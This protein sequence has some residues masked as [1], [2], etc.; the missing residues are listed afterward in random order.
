[1]DHDLSKRRQLSDSC[2]VPSGPVIGKVQQDGS[3]SLGFHGY[4][5]QGEDIAKNAKKRGLVLLFWGEKINDYNPS[6]RS[7]EQWFLWKFVTLLAVDSAAYTKISQGDDQ[8]DVNTTDW[9]KTSVFWDS[10][11]FLFHAGWFYQSH[12]HGMRCFQI[13]APELS[14]WQRTYVKYIIY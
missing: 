14:T 13:T 10:C 1:M 11:W 6:L 4:D 8:D 12:Q 7:S 9:S 5:W 2:R 3:M